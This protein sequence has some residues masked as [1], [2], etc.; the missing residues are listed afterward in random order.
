VALVEL[1]L[2]APIIIIV[3]FGIVEFGLIMY[4][5]EVSTN[6][7]REGAGLGVV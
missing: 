6:A 3:L 7:S 5:K 2:V 4:S 1:A